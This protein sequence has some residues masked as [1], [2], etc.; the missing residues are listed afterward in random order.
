MV[1]AAPAKG[2]PQLHARHV[3][4]PHGNPVAGGDHGCLDLPNRFGRGTAG[5]DESPAADEKLH[6]AALDGL[7]ADIDVG[8]PHRLHHG[9]ES[10]LVEPQPVGVDI[11]LILPNVATD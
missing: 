10:Q 6:A 8:R 11:H 3:S 9:R 7:G 5:A 1:E 4:Q 2:G